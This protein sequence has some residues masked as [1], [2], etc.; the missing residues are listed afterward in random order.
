MD[1]AVNQELN[2]QYKQVAR[3]FRNVMFAVVR[4][5]R[6]DL[7]NR[8]EAA[9]RR[10]MPADKLTDLAAVRE[11]LDTCKRCGEMDSCCCGIDATAPLTADGSELP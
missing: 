10:Y 9:M 4:A 8:V 11:Q 7:L 6:Q 5:G 2:D 1:N 3:E